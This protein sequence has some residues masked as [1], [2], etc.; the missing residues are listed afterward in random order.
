MRFYVI[1]K[2]GGGFW[3]VV[4]MSPSQYHFYEMD[5]PGLTIHNDGYELR[6]D[7]QSEADRRNFLNVSDTIPPLL[8]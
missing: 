3:E 8:N 6:A 1:S 2:V 7:A 5:N 4:K